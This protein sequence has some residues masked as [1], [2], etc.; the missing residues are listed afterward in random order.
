MLQASFPGHGRSARGDNNY[1]FL[2]LDL[3]EGAE[4]DG[5][6]SPEM[7]PDKMV[8]H[9]ARVWV[10]RAVPQEY[11]PADATKKVRMK[12]PGK[13]V[14]SLRG[15]GCEGGQV[16]L[17]REP[18]VAARAGSPPNRWVARVGAHRRRQLREHVTV[19][20]PGT[21]SNSSSDESS[22]VSSRSLR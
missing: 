12:R 19:P 15:D 17:Q 14:E 22:A 13:R 9:E 21:W 5:V 3:G 11:R 2:D 16:Q 20:S 10:R 7:Q 4:H 6:A 18:Q 8:N 1:G